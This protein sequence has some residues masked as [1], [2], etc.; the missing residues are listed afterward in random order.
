MTGTT[1]SIPAE[2]YRVGWLPPVCARHGRPATRRL[3]RTFYSRTPAWVYL[4]FV[5]GLLI[6]AIVAM[7]IRKSA[8]GSLPGCDVCVA[9]RRRFVWSSVGGWLLGLGLLVLGGM[10]DNG[11]AAILGLLVL[12]VALVWTFCG[13][14]VRVRGSLRKDQVWLDLKGVSAEFA[15]QVRAEVART[16]PG[17]GT[18]PSPPGAVAQPTTSAVTATAAPN[19]LPGG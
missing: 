13:D 14:Q 8:P 1:A 16:Q 15:A 12:L 9:E 11:P 10:A 18:L 4:L 2:W 17:G 6:A 7:A 19:I 5:F 3:K